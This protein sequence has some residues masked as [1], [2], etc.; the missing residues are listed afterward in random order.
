MGQPGPGSVGRVR[1]ARTACGTT[2]ETPALTAS[3]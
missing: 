3:A 1:L 2:A